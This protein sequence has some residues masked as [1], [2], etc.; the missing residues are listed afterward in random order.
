MDVKDKKHMK[1]AIII[2]I[3]ILLS[4]YGYMYVSKL[5][6]KITYPSYKPFI[7][8][9]Y[10]ESEFPI[11]FEKAEEL[12]LNYVEKY[13]HVP[14][15]ELVVAKISGGYPIIKFREGTIILYINI[16]EGSLSKR[17]GYVFISATSGRL[18]TLL[19]TNNDYISS[20]NDVIL[21]KERARSLIIDL[22]KELGYSIG[23]GLDI[24]IKDVKPFGHVTDI[25]YVLTVYGH[26]I[27]T[28][29][30]GET[31]WGERSGGIISICRIGDEINYVNID[32]A[33]EIEM[34][35]QGLFVK[36]DNPPISKDEA[37]SKALDYIKSEGVVEEYNYIYKGVYWVILKNKTYPHRL[38]YQ[39]V[40]HLAHY[41]IINVV[42][43]GVGQEQYKLMVDAIT[44]EIL[45][46]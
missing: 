40:P 26:E 29:G 17:F 12:A 1:I 33:I 22:F 45:G 10:N 42:F 8:K 23:N 7:R 25:D 15:D 20:C 4:L 18:L 21:S 11:N 31:Y 30:L 27:I 13:T 32:V 44:G 3:I 2:V 38:V 39:P 34:F 19:I 46:G 35:E 41:F 36:V 16:T 28:E 43:R 37:L 9:T 6:R 24:I 5:T 14:K